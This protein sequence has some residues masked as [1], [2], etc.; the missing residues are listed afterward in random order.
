MAR[1]QV[2]FVVLIIEA[3]CHAQFVFASTMNTVVVVVV[4]VAVFVVDIVV[5]VL[6]VVDVVNVV[7]VVVQVQASLGHPVT[8]A[9]EGRPP[10]V[11]FGVD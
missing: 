4:V 8:A 7:V 10:S 9:Q 6:V 11:Y 3:V 1:G 5:V 2:T